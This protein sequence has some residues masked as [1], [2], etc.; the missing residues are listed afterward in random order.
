MSAFRTI[1]QTTALTCALT[2]PLH[3][4]EQPVETPVTIWDAISFD[5]IL[6]L[7][8]QSF[9][10]TLRV[11]ADV[12][13]DQIDVD[14]V[15]NRVALVGVD[16]RPFL[17]YVEADA[18]AIAADSLV[19]SG[20]PIDRQQGYGLNIALEGAVLDFDC[21]PIEARP[22]VGMLGV[23]NI[24]LDRMTVNVKYDFASGGAMINFGADLDKLA[25]L[26]GSVDLDYISYRM[27][28][29]NE[30][31]MPAAYL[32]RV[33]VTLE[34]RGL[35]SAASRMAPPRMLDPAALEQIIPGA[36]ADMFGEMNGVDARELST[37]QDAFI[38]QTVITAKAFVANP[39][40]I[41]VESNPP[42]TPVRLGEADLEDPKALFSK[43][44][45]SIGTFPMAITTGIPAA[46][47]KQAIDGL[48]PTA[49]NLNVGRALLTGVG[50]PR[51]T[52]LGLRLLDPLAKDGEADATALMAEAMQ[53][54]N[55]ENAYRL[56]LHASS[57]GKARSLSLLND[58]EDV[59]SLA[60]M[61]EVQDS[62]LGGGEPV[63]SDFA[64]IGDIRRA[65]RGHLLGTTRIRSYRAAYYW[66]SVGA[67]TGDVASVAIRDEIDTIMRLRGASEAWSE[68]QT[69]LENGVLR[70]WVGRDLPAEL[71]K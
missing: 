16:V 6:T 33:Q 50:A 28:L 62:M 30:E 12:R 4:Q 47:L 46:E 23:D 40:Q 51:N 68:V 49:R 48:L 56:A 27:D 38:N 39:T 24:R 11:L 31:V 8:V 32:N 1:F 43:L 52:T 53:T 17:P 59:L 54:I 57:K 35:Y 36:L 60:Q 13:Y 45:P 20:Q 69:S 71:Q 70:D 19:L 15:R 29:D 7:V 25:A 21:L 14:S 66:A 26:S 55:P 64:S 22:V 44:T 10:P 18:C 58:L 67:A 42:R 34:D 5:N 63:A 65:A 37:E 41:V 3:A 9:I 2:L 61:L